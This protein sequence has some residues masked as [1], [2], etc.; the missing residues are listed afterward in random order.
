M[1][2]MKFASKSEAI[3]HLAEVTGKNIK[4]AWQDESAELLKDISKEVAKNPS[5]LLKLQ[6]GTGMNLKQ[7]LNEDDQDARIL[8]TNKGGIKIVQDVEPEVI[9]KATSAISNIRDMKKRSK[10]L[11]YVSSNKES[12]PEFHSK[13]KKGIQKDE[14]GP[15]YRSK[16]GLLQRG[17]EKLTG[18]GSGKQSVSDKASD[19]KK[20]EVKKQK[21][22]DAKELLSTYKELA[23][24]S[25]KTNLKEDTSTKQFFE[26]LFR[27]PQ[28]EAARSQFLKEFENEIKDENIDKDTAKKYVKIMKDFTNRVE[29]HLKDSG[30]DKF[31]DSMSQ[32]E[33][34]IKEAAQDAPAEVE[35]TETTSPAGK[36]EKTKGTDSTPTPVKVPEASDFSQEIDNVVDAFMKIQK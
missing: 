12:F 17:V 2:E 27:R 28:L 16:A 32:L 29:G 35:E 13:H 7:F 3:S 9:E 10:V 4:I 15:Y 1:E 11:D 30:L 33:E 21:E 31:V 20:S 5:I 26:Q 19:K 24:K 6:K 25:I 23:Q 14:N 22:E 34:D 36:S 8:P 18:E